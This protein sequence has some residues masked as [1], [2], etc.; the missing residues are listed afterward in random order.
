[1][2]LQP[3]GFASKVI[4]SIGWLATYQNGDSSDRFSLLDTVEGT[5]TYGGVSQADPALALARPVPLTNAADT[6]DW[7]RHIKRNRMLATILLTHITDGQP[8]AHDSGSSP[9]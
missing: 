6:K 8:E 1:V 5:D 9:S 2:A 4:S 3:T 7:N